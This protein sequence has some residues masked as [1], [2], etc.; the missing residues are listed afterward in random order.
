[1]MIEAFSISTAHL[2][3]NAYAEQARLRHRVFVDQRKLPHNTF[4]GMEFD[5]FDTPAAVYLVWRDQDLVVRGVARLLRT[6][7]PYMLKSY[8]P[9]LVECIQLPA[10]DDV[11]EVTRVCVDKTFHPN[12][13]RRI[14]P[15]LLCGIAEFFEANRIS[16]MIGV[17][18]EALLSHFVRQ[19]IQWL[20]PAE[21][22]EGRP[23]RAFLVPTSFIRPRHHCRAYD[24][25]ASVLADDLRWA[26]GRRAA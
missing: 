14:F 9:D 13:R 5:E 12:E 3:Q 11:W 8:W 16:G 22:V 24:I 20:G 18:S 2:F 10:R 21:I 23:E 17:T 25:P 4:D 26:P 19:G 1:M 7:M 15:E 6:T